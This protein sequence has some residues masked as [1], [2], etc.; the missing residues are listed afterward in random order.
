[1]N[2]KPAHGWAGQHVAFVFA[3]L[4]S[5]HVRCNNLHSCERK[6]T[7]TVTRFHGDCLQIRLCP[8]I[9]VEI[10]DAINWNMRILVTETVQQHPCLD[11]WEATSSNE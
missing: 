10:S 3:R 1:M 2:A 9:R 11:V 5:K 4:A 6:H 8:T 7:E